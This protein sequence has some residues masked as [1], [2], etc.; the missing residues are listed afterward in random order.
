MDGGGERRPVLALKMF[1]WLVG[2][3]PGHS[4]LLY[5][6]MMEGEGSAIMAYSNGQSRVVVGPGSMW[7]GRLSHDGRW[8]T[9]YALNSGTF[10][11]YVTPFP[12]G[13]SRWLIAEGTD[14]AWGD[15]GKEIYYRSGTRLMAARV[16]KTAGVKVVTNRVVIEPFLPPLYDDYDIHPDGRTVV[17][18]R[19]VNRTQ[20]REVTMVL[21]WFSEFGPDDRSRSLRY[22][23]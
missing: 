6:R 14:P 17:L 9:Y 4:A 18:V 15:D 3:A 10:E 12:G 20:G 21:G 11:V 16:E 22:S 23:P 1:H 7:G 13:G 19:P 2:W 8:L 5:G